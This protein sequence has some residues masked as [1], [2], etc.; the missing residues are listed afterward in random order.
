MKYRHD[1]FS[2]NVS[3]TFVFG[4]LHVHTVTL[5]A[6][7]IS[8]LIL[9]ALMVMEVVKVGF[10]ADESK[11]APIDIWK[12][13]YWL[14]YVVAFVCIVLLLIG[15][16]FKKP[17]LYYPTTCF[18]RI[19]LIVLLFFFAYCLIDNYAYLQLNGEDLLEAKKKDRVDRFV[20]YTSKVI[21]RDFYIAQVLICSIGIYFI[22]IA[23]KDF[24]YVSKI[25]TS[26]VYRT[27]S[28]VLSGD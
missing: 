4:N 16:V 2:D 13:F 11:Q 12:I 20:T 22:N 19:Y 5:I 24:L 8:S 3:S 17:V 26:G 6:S 14:S 27:T 21:E 25:T 23:S 18:L 10:L 9:V 15:N 1:S 7:I 28:P